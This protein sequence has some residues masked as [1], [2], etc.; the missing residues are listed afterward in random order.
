MLRSLD[1][2]NPARLAAIRACTVSF[3]VAMD[4]GEGI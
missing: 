3:L 1:R 4:M 2:M